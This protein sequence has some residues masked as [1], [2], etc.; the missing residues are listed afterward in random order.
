MHACMNEWAHFRHKNQEGVP[1]VAQWV[2]N[3]T[4][5]REDVDLIP[6]LTRCVK[7]PALPGAVV[8]LTDAAL[9]SC[10]AVAR[11]VAVVL[12]RPLAWEL[13]Y[14][15][16]VALKSKLKKKKLSKKGMRMRR[17]KVFGT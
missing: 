1:V 4:K 8:Q 13:P 17:A 14:A 9:W 6:G 10:L 3:P 11:A 12:I 16:S 5:I 15:T 7:D 2:M